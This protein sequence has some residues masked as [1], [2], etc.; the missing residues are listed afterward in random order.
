MNLFVLDRSPAT[1]ARLHSDVHVIKM[2]LE[3]A[4]ILCAALHRHGLAAPYRPT[5]C[6]HPSV[7]W[8]GDALAHWRWTREL[9]LALAE[10]YTWRFGKEHKCGAVIAGLPEA[11]P[12][13][14]LPW[15]EPPQAMPDAYRRDDVVAAYRAYYAGAKASFPG[16][17]PASW[18][19][20]PVPAWMTG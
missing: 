9:G 10:E 20:R 5:H 19:R 15:R 16:K 7:L 8:A 11:P 12:L 3:T 2:C 18:T 1:A 13:P 14:D 17:G 4:Q 6:G